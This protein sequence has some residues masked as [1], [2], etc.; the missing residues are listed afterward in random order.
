MTITTP[1]S[2]LHLPPGDWPTV[3]DCLCDHFAT[4][5]RAQWLDRIARGRVLGADGVPIT[6][7]TPYRAGLPVRYFREVADEP[8]IPGEVRIVYADEHLLVADKPPFLPVT[9]AGI[10]V[11][12]TLLARLVAA[13][14]HAGLV[15]LHRIDRLTRGLVMFSIR[16][17]TRGAYQALFRERRIGKVYEALAPPLPALDFPSVRRSRIERG[18]PFFR[19]REVAGEPNSETRIDVIERGETLW[20]YRLDP[21]TGRKHQLRVQMAGLGAAIAN[22]PL[23]PQLQPE[24]PDDPARP[25]RLLASELAFDDP[26]SGEGRRFCSGL[27]V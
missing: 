23:Y 20:R 17:D 9:P 24:A 13:T 8:L 26:V 19:M 6:A 12:Q 21:V 3:L 10:Y 18:E 11:T 14:G 16:P 1:A 25:L 2:T 7:H 5:G 15:P 27:S 4:I 22:D